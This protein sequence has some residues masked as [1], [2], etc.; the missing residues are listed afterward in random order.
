M[1]AQRVVP[2]V[3]PVAPGVELPNMAL[4]LTAPC[5]LVVV[6]VG[7]VEPRAQPP[8]LPLARWTL[9]P[10]ALRRTGAAAQRRRSADYVQES[11]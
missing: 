3:G 11:H 6:T 9:Q 8:G 4:E 7:P 5:G 1:L 2:Q 10:G